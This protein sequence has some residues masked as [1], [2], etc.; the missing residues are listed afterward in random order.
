MQE[1]GSNSYHIN[2][3]Y[4]KPCSGPIQH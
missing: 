3:Y 1:V 2:L 4:L